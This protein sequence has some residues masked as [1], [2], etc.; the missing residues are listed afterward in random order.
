MVRCNQ[1]TSAYEPSTHAAARVSVAEVFAQVRDKRIFPI[2][3]RMR[4]NTGK[5]DQ[6]LY[7]K[8]H[9]EQG[10]DTNDCRILRMEIER[11]I[12]RGQ[13]REFTREKGHEKPQGRGASQPRYPPWHI[14]TIAVGIHGG[15][16]SRNSRKKYARREVYGVVD[17]Q[18]GTEA[19]TF[20]DADCLGL[21]MPHDDPL[22]IAPNIAHY[23]VE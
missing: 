1:Q 21:E 3:G 17:L 13:L 10:H 18:V 20:T 12:Q 19:I 11:L 4:G 23:T 8:Y 2:P 14:A 22:V 15:G 16:D 7:C 9:R 5:R 6:N